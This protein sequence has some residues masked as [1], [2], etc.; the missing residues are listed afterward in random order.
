MMKVRNLCGLFISIIDSKVYLIHQ[1]AREFLIRTDSIDQHSN[2]TEADVR[3]WRVELDHLNFL[4]ANICISYLLFTTFET[5]P[6]DANDIDQY[7]NEHAFLEYAATH[8]A[9]HYRESEIRRDTT[10]LESTMNICNHQS[11]RFRTWIQVYKR[12]LSDYAYF[13]E[14]AN[15]L[16]VGSYFGLEDMVEKLLLNGADIAAEDKNGRTALY[17]ATQYEHKAVVKLLLEKGADISAK[18]EEGWT[19]IDLASKEGH[20]VV[21]QLL[22]SYTLV[23]S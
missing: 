4:M 5:C 9:G 18:D 8:W 17:L 19:A 23:S 6:P 1:T 7:C 14:S 2:P 16:L 15:N 10:L 13:P 21:V 3:I 20:E 22:T 11:S 12:N